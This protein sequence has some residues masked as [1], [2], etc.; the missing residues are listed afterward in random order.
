MK[1]PIFFA[2]ASGGLALLAMTW[3]AAMAGDFY[4]GQTLRLMVFGAPGGGYDTYTRMI[5]RHIGQ[6]IPGN[7]ST[8]VEN[9]TGAGGLVLANYLYKRAEPDGLTI[10]TFNNS[11]IVQKALGDPRIRMDF[12]KFGWIGAPSVGA[13]V[14]MV[15]GFTGLK[16]LE[17]VLKYDKPLKVGATRAGS[18][19]YDLPLI[20]NKTLGTQF[21]VV[22]GYTGTATTRIALQKGELQAFCSQWESMRVTA[23]S[24]L[25]AQGEDKLI[26]FIINEGEWNDPEVKNLPTFRQAIKDPKKYP[27]Y[28]SW[29][30]QMDFQRAFS[31]PPGTA[32]ARIATLRAAFMK[33]LDDPELLKEAKKT[34]L[35]ITPVSGEKVEKLVGQILDMP[36]EVKENLAFLV[37]KPKS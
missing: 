33:T 18:T 22:S 2:A 7:P 27:I 9:M 34:K 26:P 4:Q 14:C 15:M 32:K 13:P 16:T 37:R 12:K 30:F 11:L 36:T 17:D 6:Y 31:A 28:E 1:K 19:G 5:A 10:G 23:R 29:A 8:V 20:M 25:D 21:E 24:M 35:V 3:T